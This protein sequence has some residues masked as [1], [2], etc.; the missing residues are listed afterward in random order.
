[1]KE[2]GLRAAAVVADLLTVARGVAATR[3]LA[4]LNDIIFDYTYSPEF[5]KLKSLYTK[6]D[7]TRQE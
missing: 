5:Q 6:I 4:N 1:M 2:A 7:F 3:E